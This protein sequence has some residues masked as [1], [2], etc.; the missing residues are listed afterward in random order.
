M[1]SPRPDERPSRASG[2]IPIPRADLLAGFGRFATGLGL[3]A[4]GVANFIV[5]DFVAGRA[6][7]WHPHKPGQHVWA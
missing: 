3:V 4:F 1:S 6:P 5:G 2:A 7:A